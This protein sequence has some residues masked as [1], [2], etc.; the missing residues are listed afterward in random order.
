MRLH[1]IIAVALIAAPLAAQAK[2]RPHLPTPSKIPTPASVLGFEPG[3]DRKLPSWKQVVEYFTKL[4]AASP[5]ITVRTL[6]KTTL[7][8]PFIA[9]FIGDAGVI[10]D[11]PNWRA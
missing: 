6:G 2:A 9:A 10:A 5:R 4:D 8:R 11:L 1:S 7:G 3:A